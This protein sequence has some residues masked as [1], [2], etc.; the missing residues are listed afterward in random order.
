MILI[1]IAAKKDT[2]DY[3]K[4]WKKNAKKNEKDLLEEEKPK[5]YLNSVYPDGK[6]PDADLIE[7]LE[8]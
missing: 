6:G 8:S 2:K 7:G 3:D 5:T 1:I 4:P